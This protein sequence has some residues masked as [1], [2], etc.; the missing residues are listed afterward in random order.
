MTTEGNSEPTSPLTLEFGP[1]LVRDGMVR[2]PSRSAL[3][4]VRA[5]LPADLLSGSTLG[6][7]VVDGPKGTIDLREVLYVLQDELR[8]GDLFSIFVDDERVHLALY[9]ADG[10]EP[11][12]RNHT[13]RSV[14]TSTR[15]RDDDDETEY[16][17]SAL[18][19]GENL[20][21]DQ[22]RLE[23]FVNSSSYQEDQSG[24]VSIKTLIPTR[25]SSAEELS[26]EIYELA[27]AAT[28]RPHLPLLR[29]ELI[30][31]IDRA[32]TTKEVAEVVAESGYRNEWA[33][34]LIQKKV[35]EWTTIHGSPTEG[36]TTNASSAKLLDLLWSEIEIERLQVDTDQLLLE[37]L[38]HLDVELMPHQLAAVRSAL[39][40]M[41]GKAILAD[42]VGL[43]KTIEAG[44]IAHILLARGDIRTIL[45][46]APKTLRSQW[47]E[48]L[49][50]KFDINIVDATTGDDLLAYAHR[51]ATA[52]SSV[53]NH[54]I[55]MTS[56]MLARNFDTV[57]K[58]QPDLIIIDE[59]HRVAKPSTSFRER[60]QNLMATAPYA[61]FLTATPVQN[62]LI[63]LYNLVELLRPGTFGSPSSFRKRFVSGDERIP[64]QTALDGLRQILRRVLVRWTRAQAGLDSVLRI[65][66]DYPI[67]L[68][69]SE[70]EIYQAVFEQGAGLYREQLAYHRNQISR[71]LAECFARSPKAALSSLIRLADRHPHRLQEVEQ[72]KSKLAHLSIST[73]EA[74][75][76]E[77]VTGWVGE[78]G[79]V[80]VFAQHL[81]VIDRLRQLLELNG[82]STS[83][84]HGK[85]SATAQAEAR[86]EFQSSTQVFLSTD[87]GAEGINLQFANCI[88]NYDLP[89]NPMTIE[90]RIGR[91][92][93][94]GQTRSVYIA[95]LFTPQTFE[96]RLYELLN[97]KLHL[98]ELLFGEYS[99]ILGEI[100]WK[101]SSFTEAVTDVAISSGKRQED[102]AKHVGNELERAYASLLDDKKNESALT[103]WYALSARKQSR[104]ELHGAED[105]APSVNRDVAIRIR[106]RYIATLE[107]SLIALDAEITHAEVDK[108]LIEVRLP[109]AFAREISAGRTNRA[110]LALVPEG[111]RR[112]PDAIPAG[113]SSPF[114]RA[115]T[116]YVR[117]R[118]AGISLTLESE[119]VSPEL[120][121]VDHVKELTHLRREVEQE[122][123]TIGNL[124]QWVWRPSDGSPFTKVIVEPELYATLLPGDEAGSSPAVTAH[125]VSTT[126]LSESLAPD[127]WSDSSQ[128]DMIIEIETDAARR[129]E[130]I[131]AATKEEISE[132]ATAYADTSQFGRHDPERA[133][134][135]ARLTKQISTKKAQAQELEGR[136]ASANGELLRTLSSSL[137]RA[138]YRVVDA[139]S[140]PDGSEI[141]SELIVRPHLRHFEEATPAYDVTINGSPLTKLTLCDFGHIDDT[142]NV[143]NCAAC[144]LLHCMS[145]TSPKHL[146][147]LCKAVVGGECWQEEVELCK[148][149][150]PEEIESDPA[151]G[152]ASY[153]TRTGEQILASKTQLLILP[154]GGTTD[155]P[156]RLSRSLAWWAI[157]PAWDLVHDSTMLGE[158]RST[159]DVGPLMIWL[160]REP[161][162]LGVFPRSTGR[163]LKWASENFVEPSNPIDSTD[164]SPRSDVERRVIFTVRRAVLSID[165]ANGTAT[166]A[167]R[168]TAA[169]RHY[170]FPVSTEA[171]STVSI[172]GVSAPQLHD[173]VLRH[174][175][176]DLPRRRAIVRH[177]SAGVAVQIEQ[178]SLILTTF[179]TS[180]DRLL[181]A[182]PRVVNVLGP[183]LRLDEEVES[184]STE[185][186]VDDLVPELSYL[187]GQFNTIGVLLVRVGEVISIFIDEMTSDDELTLA[188][189]LNALGRFAGLPDV[190]IEGVDTRRN[191]LIDRPFMESSSRYTV[192][193]LGRSTSVRGKDLPAPATSPSAIQDVFE[194]LDE[195]HMDVKR[196]VGRDRIASRIARGVDS[197]QIEITQLRYVDQLVKR[198]TLHEPRWL[199]RLEELSLEF[200]ENNGGGVQARRITALVGPEDHMVWNGSLCGNDHQVAPDLRRW[201]DRC[202]LYHCPL[203]AVTM[204]TCA[205]C[206]SVTCQATRTPRTTRTDSQNTCERCGTKECARCGVDPQIAV[207]PRCLRDTCSYCRATDRVCATCAR[208]PEEHWSPPPSIGE[209]LIGLHFEARTEL[210]PPRSGLALS[211]T[212]VVAY[213]SWRAERF[214]LQD[215]TFDEW[216]L[217]TPSLNYA[218]RKALEQHFHGEV[219]IQRSRESTAGTQA[220]EHSLLLLRETRPLHALSIS[221]ESEPQH[222]VRF[223]LV[224]KNDLEVD[225][226][227]LSVLNDELGLSPSPPPG[228]ARHRTEPATF[229]T[230]NPVTS[231]DQAPQVVLA[232]RS[233]PQR[234]DY[235]L[236][237][238][239]VVRQITRTSTDVNGSD[240]PPIEQLHPLIDPTEASSREL[241]TVMTDRFH[242]T[243]HRLGRAFRLT[244]VLRDGS[245]QQHILGDD[246]LGGVR[247]R[248]ATERRLSPHVDVI[249]RQLPPHLEPSQMPV[250]LGRSVRQ[251][252]PGR[253]EVIVPNGHHP[254]NY[255]AWTIGGVRFVSLEDEI[256]TL[257]ASGLATPNTTPFNGS[258]VA[259][260][261]ALL[262]RFPF[263]ERH[264]IEFRQRYQVTYGSLFR[265]TEVTA[266]AY[267]GLDM[268]F[269]L[270]FAG[271]DDR[272]GRWVSTFD[273]QQGRPQLI[274]NEGSSV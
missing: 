138:Q 185:I 259:V 64:K 88:V 256:E 181:L 261:S 263:T 41:N 72:L 132:L 209:H 251:M 146:C 262:E 39:G 205:D 112:H 253:A 57:T 175:H 50:T 139:W 65:P 121:I 125:R 271:E 58:L 87:A 33:Q 83:L 239:G 52:T 25:R 113:L 196:E 222:S 49:R 7:V 66:K 130:E 14:R 5:T 206:S 147:H 126:P 120:I 168:S 68:G 215:G 145:C 189:G 11:R 26:D 231:D 94:T 84:F 156:D 73:R 202:N 273:I 90:Q 203:C 158:P 144:G 242:A 265:R 104:G 169:P 172:E 115:W 30:A 267:P 8:N 59:A 179:S 207:C 134:R 149:C 213:N 223:D 37:P 238:E 157:T 16:E 264:A 236:D 229:V 177:E 140:S 63:E 81:D 218:A 269:V 272:T 80:V 142:A 141:Q 18:D 76:L 195:L 70:L 82:F 173:W 101:Y 245:S 197:L 123:V 235:L 257:E 274:D 248:Y 180:E 67:E 119:E 128:K 79:K 186:S 208:A 116:T 71:F 85:L 219:V 133:T 152:L 243:L 32:K 53:S 9:P 167:G 214:V 98:F 45:I 122:L 60:M 198:N 54:G 191:P 96:A 44:A 160:E 230:S 56:Q 174:F 135:L 216:R 221:T 102:A 164:T 227:L 255:S 183:A 258:S 247:E 118:L 220:P 150:A 154:E 38:D 136:G 210:L 199:E 188:T 34:S 15:R 170:E 252:L 178:N 110:Q 6:Q 21:I 13:K 42:E 92:H 184:P 182:E 22:R 266:Y 211:E 228:L 192:R 19:R 240:E 124:S 97:K 249:F 69:E 1:S 165:I 117:D 10:S 233:C 155:I 114:L 127:P 74:V 3:R 93:R 131:L 108:S 234:T 161:K 62:D 4:N 201:C 226:V 46:I 241:G 217:L 187:I 107:R 20:S 78:H 31:L 24:D 61:L 260:A 176:A 12:I 55:V 250:C 17:T 40:P 246:P 35:R 270:A 106:Q 204:S 23:A 163:Y 75:L 212:V 100:D 166:P 148:D 47:Q 137:Q 171:F 36:T 99:T 105:L 244:L 153:R 224:G 151:T 200:T 129:T 103:T 232:V 109:D 225:A 143:W 2:L 51:K 89:W 111:L 193:E 194:L 237:A 48:E 27:N 95:N 28:E 91:L 268:A 190:P 159:V 43:G 77:I 29:D 254:S 86:R 162:K